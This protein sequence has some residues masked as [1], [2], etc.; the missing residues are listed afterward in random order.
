MLVALLLPA[1]QAAR[2]AARRMQC[3]NNLKQLGLAVH[4]FHDTH[5]RFPCQVDDPIFVSQRLVRFSFFIAIMPYIEQNAAFDWIIGAN[6]R[7]E[8]PLTGNYQLASVDEPFNAADSPLRVRNAAFMCPSEGH[9]GIGAGALMW[10][11]FTATNYRG[12][13][14]DTLASIRGSNVPENE[15]NNWVRAHSP[16]SWLRVGPQRINVV[17]PQPVAN[18]NGGTIGLV[19]VSSGTTNTLLIT[20]GVIFDGTGNESQ[21]VDFRANHVNI[22]PDAYW[23]NRVPN[24]CLNAKGSGGRTRPGPTSMHYPT[25]LPGH[26]VADTEHTYNTAVFTLLPPNSPNCSGGN[27]YGG[28]A[29]SSRH[30]GGVGGVLVDGSVRFITDSVHTKNLSVPGMHQGGSNDERMPSQPI[31]GATG[32]DATQGQPFSW[33]MWA[34]FGAINSMHSISL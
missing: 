6:S 33:G 13:M 3:S 21:Q 2:E 9:T 20:E 34:E 4:N 7:R 18:R 5:N 23:Y 29:A 27:M 1:V 14:G 32:G 19:A 10:N 8:S 30:P 26:N 17:N 15:D 16:R 22:S 24:N 31:A 28:H 11:G 12:S 25:H